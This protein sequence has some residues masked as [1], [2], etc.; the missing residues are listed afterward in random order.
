MGMQ[1]CKCDNTLVIDCKACG[2][3]YELQP[4]KENPAGGGW[5]S[6]D[7]DFC[8]NCDSSNLERRFKDGRPALDP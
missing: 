6:S 5:Y 4:I 7:K 2:H 1:L 3:T 8:T